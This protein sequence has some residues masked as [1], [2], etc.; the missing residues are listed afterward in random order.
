MN[1][2]KSRLARCVDNYARTGTTSSLK[3]FAEA[4]NI[5]IERRRLPAHW[6]VVIA[7]TICADP[8]FMLDGRI[9]PGRPRSKKMVAGLMRRIDVAACRKEETFRVLIHSRGWAI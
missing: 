5:V 2:V 8:R 1:R 9:M 3:G 6:G 4:D 7:E